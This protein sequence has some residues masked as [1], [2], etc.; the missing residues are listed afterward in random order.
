MLALD[1][2]ADDHKHQTTQQAGKGRHQER[3]LHWI[4]QCLG[5]PAEQGPGADA[6]HH[7][8]R[9]QGEVFHPLRGLDEH[10]HDDRPQGVKHSPA[11]P[12]HQAK[13]QYCGAMTRQ[14]GET[15]AGRGEQQSPAGYGPGSAEQ[16]GQMAGKNHG[17][18]GAEHGDRDDRTRIRLTAAVGTEH[19]GQ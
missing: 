19:H 14:G 17:H 18:K 5:G 4:T 15:Q 9:E 13:D 10:G 1:F 2:R 7:A 12:Q 3:R 8:A 11:Q 6:G 16:V